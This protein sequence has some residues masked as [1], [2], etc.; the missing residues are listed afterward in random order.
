MRK[1]NFFGT[2]VWVG[3]IWLTFESYLGRLL[4][5]KTQRIFLTVLVALDRLP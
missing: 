2:T 4:A 1:T 3:L 5:V